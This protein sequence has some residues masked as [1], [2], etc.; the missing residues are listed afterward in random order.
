MAAARHSL[1]NTQYAHVMSAVEGPTGLPVV[2]ADIAVQYAPPQ[3]PGVIRRYQIPLSC[4]YTYFSCKRMETRNPGIVADYDSLRV[5]GRPAK[6]LVVYGTPANVRKM[7]EREHGIVGDYD[8]TTAESWPIDA[9]TSRRVRLQ[10][11]LR[12]WH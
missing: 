11:R 10:I 6:R 1:T 4:G 9:A 12:R 7:Y 8:P 2:L 3:P 5:D